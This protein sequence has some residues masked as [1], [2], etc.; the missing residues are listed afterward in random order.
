MQLCQKHWLMAS[1]TLLTLHELLVIRFVEVGGLGIG[2]VG[3]HK[4]ELFRNFT[5]L[6]NKRSF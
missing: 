6:I 1:V 4:E 5:K 3:Y 2:V